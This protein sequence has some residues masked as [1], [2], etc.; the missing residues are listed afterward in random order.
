MI[1]EKASRRRH[2]EGG[3]IWEEASGEEAFK[4]RH[5]GGLWAALGVALEWLRDCS[6]K[7]LGRLREELRALGAL[8]QRKNKRFFVCFNMVF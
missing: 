7:A 5:I 3:G 8:A 2:L 4:W 1:G 6:G